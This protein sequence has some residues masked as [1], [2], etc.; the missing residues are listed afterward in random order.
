MVHDQADSLRRQLE[1]SK[2]PREAKT[3]SFVSGKGGVGKSNIAVNFSL[4]LCRLGNKV[5]LI[6][7]DIGMGNVEIL[8][9]LHAEKTIV[10]MLQDNLPIYDIM[11]VGPNNLSFIAGGSGLANLFSMDEYK[12]DYFLA[13]Y[14][15]ITKEYDYI[16]FDMGAGATQASIDFV[17]ASDEC[18]V[19]TTPEPTSI[20]DAYSMIKHIISYN[21][22]VPFYVVLNR[23][24][25]IKN[26]L[27]TV[28]RFR[29]V[30][31]QFLDIEIKLLGI[32]PEDKA[33]SAAVIHQAPFVLGN[34]KT[35][36]TKS[37][38]QLA[39]KYSNNVVGSTIEANTSFIDRLKDLL[40]NR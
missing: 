17:L 12:M 3:I 11:E 31:M 37:I 14:Q 5:M 18:I 23:A 4:E 30:I 16:I 34:E 20:T 21:R 28:D 15:S 25:T 1:I 26:G 29:K 36:I 6:D 33:V 24:D 2:H 22:Q 39:E 19:V 13:Q 35:A 40:R 10:D 7:L 9:G 32:L 8:L 38:K 27:R